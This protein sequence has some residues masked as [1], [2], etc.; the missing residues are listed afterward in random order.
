MPIEF[1]VSDVIPAS[2]QE[3]YDAWLS[4][5]GHAEITGGQPA[6]ASPEEGAVHKAWDGYING[7]NLKLEPGK[8]IVQ[9]WRTA[10]FARGNPDSQ[11]E[12]LLEAVPG[13]T[14]VTLHHTNVPDG[15]PNYQEGWQTHYFEPMKA[16]FG[17]A[18]KKI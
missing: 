11:I 7:T 14:K 10:E 15:Q 8:R 13:G 12:V 17:R 6:E 9:S 1:T 2:P 4:S 5:E 18:K 3:I 16:H